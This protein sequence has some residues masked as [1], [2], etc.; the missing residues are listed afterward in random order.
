MLTASQ[1]RQQMDTGT[2]SGRIEQPAQELAAVGG[3]QQH[4]HLEPA[5]PSRANRVSVHRLW[6]PWPVRSHL[7]DSQ[8]WPRVA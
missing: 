7:D 8:V 6:G 4:S 1:H 3:M 5:E 2:A